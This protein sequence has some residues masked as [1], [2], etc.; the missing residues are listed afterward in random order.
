MD[1]RKAKDNFDKERDMRKC[2]KYNKV[3]YIVKDY[4]VGQ[5]MKNKSIQKESDE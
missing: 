1:I 3:E 5:N 2:Y 4:K